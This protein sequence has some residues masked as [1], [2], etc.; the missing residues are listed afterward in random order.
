MVTEFVNTEAEHFSRRDIFAP[1]CLRKRQSWVF[2]LIIVVIKCSLSHISQ[3][4]K[5]LL[6]LCACEL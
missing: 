5:I 1:F 6:F 4:E 2:D 3:L